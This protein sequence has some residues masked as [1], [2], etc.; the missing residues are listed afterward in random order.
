MRKIFSLLLLVL[1]LISGPTGALPA[2]SQEVTTLIPK[3]LKLS[4]ELLSSLSTKTNHK[5]DKFSCKVLAPAELSGAIVT[6]HVKKA[7][8]SGKATGK[9]E[10]DLG[11][12]AIT[13]S[14]GR[15]SSFNAQI[16]E[17]YDVVDAGAQGRADNEGT[18]KSRSTVKRDAVRVGVSTA[19][20]ALI[21]GL[22]GGGKGAAIGA[23][24][25]AGVGVSTTLATK[26]PE[27]EF[28]Q[29]TQ[30]TVVL[31]SPSH[32]LSE[33]EIAKLG[34]VGSPSTN[35]S[36]PA[37]SSGPVLNT[38]KAITAEPTATGSKTE[39]V[40][41]PIPNPHL[42]SST[43]RVY[44]AEGYQLSVPENWRESSSKDPVTLAPEGGY[45]F[46]EGKPNLTHGIMT[47]AIPG[48]TLPLSQANERLVGAVL[49]TNTYLR[50]GECKPTIFGSQQYVTC[51]L[52]GVSPATG[53]AEIVNTY[54]SMM[55]AG[56]LF[57]LIAVIPEDQYAAYEAAFQ[58]I[59]LNVQF[60]R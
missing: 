9:S 46:Y 36:S 19:V 56:K 28:P 21:G 45:S 11:F 59:V 39:P 17:V 32:L 58:R 54:T 50:L 16:L 3:N 4:L 37:G 2:R 1:F 29:G 33:S 7:K 25:G 30:L 53:K 27:L 60:D 34:T 22:L 24:I 26:G 38:T 12:D 13:L 43:L 41:R 20:G 52:S 47:G 18:L 48:Q 57:Y 49:T 44:R 31:N 40:M 55:R 35:V 15:F 23:A 8:G 6:G 10:M 5:G 51:K 42:P 14:D